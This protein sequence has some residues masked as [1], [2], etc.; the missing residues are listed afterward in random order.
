MMNQ[1]ERRNVSKMRKIIV[2][3]VGGLIVLFIAL[4][5][6]I[7]N[8]ENV[9]VNDNFIGPSGS[10]GERDKDS[11]FN[12]LAVSPTNP[13]IVY[14][15]TELNGIFKSID[16]GDNW[17]SLQSGL[18]H[19]RRSYPEVYD[20][21]INPTDEDSV[22]AALTNGPQPPSVE[23]A[24]GFYISTNAGENWHRRTEGLP[25]TAVNSLALGDDLMTLFVGID[26]QKPS[27]YRVKD[28]VTGGIYKSHNYGETWESVAIPDIGIGNKF[29]RIAVRRNYIYS[30]GTS[31][32]DVKPGEPRLPDPRRSVGLIRS[33]DNGK[34]WEQINPTGVLPGNFDVSADA[35][36]IYFSTFQSG[37]T[38][39]SIDHGNSWKEIFSSRCGRIKISPFKSNVVF[40][41]NGYQLFA[42]SDSLKSGRMVL[43]TQGKII[44]DI[45]FTSD[46]NIIY[47]ATDGYILYKSTNGGTSFSEVA[48]LRTHI[49]KKMKVAEK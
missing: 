47:V 33:A 3:V 30:L 10:D 44:N 31:Y 14:L 4:G 8:E 27:N 16:G 46:P 2:I 20:I 43:E 45:E 22:Y 1:K 38:Y 35:S 15:G 32:I 25:N 37:Q 41:A 19:N 21:L 17:E 42:S 28:G 7:N 18:Y 26:G 11:V 49:Y 12:S 40:C 29:V 13:K 36:T 34:S 5:L 39:R 23:K 9:S 48:N 6:F 24:A